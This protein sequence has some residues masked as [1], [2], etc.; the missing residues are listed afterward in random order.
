MK[1]LSVFLLM[2]LIVASCTKEVPENPV[3]KIENMKD[4]VATKDFNWESTKV[5][6]FELGVDA[7]LASGNLSVISIYEKDPSQTEVVLAKGTAGYNIDWAPTLR[8]PS[9]ISEVY[10]K[11]QNAQGTIQIV[12]L[13][14]NGDFVSHRFTETL[15]PGGNFKSTLNGPD[16]TTGCDQTISGN[17]SVIINNGQTYCV[18]GSY[19]GNLSFYW[20]SNGGTLRVCG[21]ANLGN[22]TLGNNCHIVVAQGGTFT[23][24]SIEL[25]GNA[26]I[27]VYNNAQATFGTLNMN[28]TSQLT[29]NNGQVTINNN[30]QPNS[31][32][33][34]YGTIYVTGNYFINSNVG[35]LNNAGTVTI[36]GL[37]EVNKSLTNNGTITVQNSISFNSSTVINNCQ[38]ST[39]GNLNVNGGTFTSN[40]GYFR[41]MGRTNVNGNSNMVLQ[42]KSM[43]H[44][45]NITLNRGFS[46]SGS[47]NTVKVDAETRINNVNVSGA[48]EFADNDGVIVVG[49]VANF[50]NGATFVTHANITNY[51]PVSA[52]NPSGIG[53]PTIIDA[54]GDGVPDAQDDYPNDPLRAFNNYYPNST[55]WASMAFEDLWPGTGDYDFNDLVVAYR[56]NRVTNA[57]NKVVNMQMIYQVKAVGASLK[58]GFGVQLDNV[59][60]N[61]ISSVSGYDIDEGY[62]NLSANGTEN[63]QAKA[64]IILW[65]NVDNVIT[66]AGGSMFNTVHNNLVGTSEVLTVNVLFSTPLEQN[67]LG[68]APFNH[69]LIKNMERGVEIHMADKIPTSLADLNLFGTA[70]DDS[71]PSTGKYYKTANNLPWGINLPVIFDYPVE[72][73]VILQSHLHFAEWATSSGSLFPDWYENKSGYR[74]T[75][76]IY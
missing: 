73:S 21:T 13:S 22:V 49:S 30:F 52:C 5:V 37:L 61:Q 34:N 39:Q 43:L 32:V 40:A 62:I 36:G 10:V 68:V 54:D 14:I 28:A 56:I 31:T 47:L 72:G 50:V 16:C 57:G 23:A 74:N 67:V 19:N 8:I 53:T 71:N 51:I 1:K 9:T 24:T 63:N 20:W 55:G 25:N 38:I 69:F 12:K 48:I 15:A 75:Q 42:N 70:K 46:G 76:Y 41:V 2:A 66:R 3:P 59:L 44:T 11:L 17:T 35:F 26:T 18:T 58:N 33:E 45:N 64:V 4:L 60:P 27:T 6:S 65:D 29:N 7:S